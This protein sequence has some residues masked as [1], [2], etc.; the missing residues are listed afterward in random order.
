MITELQLKNFRGFKDHTIPLH[1]V[2]I[3]V[4][5]N[6]AGKSTIVEALRLISIVVTRF[7]GNLGRIPPRWEFP[8][9]SRGP[10]PFKNLEI[11]L[12]SVFHGY[13][14]PPATIRAY[15]SSGHV[16]QITIDHDSIVAGRLRTTI[17]RSE[18]GVISRVS[19]QP[20]VAPVAREERLL[21]EDYVRGAIS[22][23]LA[24]L[25]FRNQLHFLSEH[26]AEFKDAVETTWPGLRIHKLD[27]NGK[28]PDDVFLSLLVED[29][30][31][32]AELSWMGHGLQ[33]WLQ[34]IW[35]LTRARDHETVILDEPDVYMHADLQR[36]LI[37]FVQSRH[38][39]VIIATHSS[40]IMAEVPPECILIVDRT[41]RQSA[42]ATS[43]PAVQRV[44]GSF[45]SVHNL[46]LSR[47]WNSR[48]FLMIEG[49]D[50]GLLKPIQNVLYPTSISPIDTVPARSVGGWGGWN[51]AVGSEMFLQNAG[52]EGIVTY[53]IFDSDYHTPK[54][55]TQRQLE[56]KQRGIALHIWKRKEIENYL[57]VPA[58]I[59]RA[60][61]KQL[62]EGI[63]APSVEQIERRLEK[64]AE[65]YRE[66]VT[67][68]L[69]T[70]IALADRKVMAGT[71]NQ[72]AR[73]LVSERWETQAGRFSIIPG[74]KV[75]SKL[76]NWLEKKY[77]VSV[78]A[79]AIAYSL[80]RNEVDEELRQVIGS[81]EEG[82]A[83]P[84]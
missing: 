74:K 19:I 53:C 13:G 51:Y 57:L 44:L 9:N 68:C 2:T 22:S 43:L 49:E 17:A 48:R 15:F 33:M 64:I 52:G 61:Q 63:P 35:F 71:A 72:Q 27:K 83:F 54:E 59:Q 50:L 3:V 6:N 14:D 79:A 24:P 69:A 47:L 34:T 58:A 38:K 37:R 16:I 28:I 26:F 55:I 82:V 66:E 25:H 1:P 46:Q 78:G 11:N 80:A 60:V 62:A 30:H 12:K 42:F 31:F 18:E 36:R 84:D 75:L 10:E 76:A 56:A 23:A 4:G 77:Q 8:R 73:V 45:G 7:R 41:K 81:I 5:R 39:Q 65:I 32:P 70:S 21:T 40:E 67:D 29:H 20:Q